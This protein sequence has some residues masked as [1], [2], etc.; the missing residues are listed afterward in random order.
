MRPLT[1][2]A[3][4]L[5]PT[6]LAQPA[7]KPAA[8]APRP[9]APK[10]LDPN[11]PIPPVGKPL[12]PA[13]RA[14]LENAVANLATRIAV[15]KKDLAA[16]PELLA[17]VPDIQIYHNAVRYPLQY[18]EPIDVKQAHQ[19][20][21]DAG[22]RIDQLTAGDVK[23]IHTT[24][25][26]GY[27]SAIDGS[28]QPYNLS[29]PADYK[30][31]DPKK[32]RVD[33]WAHGRNENLTELAFL[34]SKTKE[35]QPA[36]HFVVYLYGRYCNAN[37]FAGEVDCFE[38]LADLKR[39]V[40]VD[41]NRL[42]TIGFSMGGAAV[43]QFATHYTD[44][45]AAASP[46][47]GFSESR[48]F[49]KIKPDEIAAMQPWE[50][51]LWHWYDCTDWVENL[52]MLPTVAYAGELD[53]QKQASDVMLREAAKEQVKI[54]R[55]IGP[56]TAHK[57]EP[58]TK[59]KI[60]A[61]L[62]EI[63]AKGRDRLPSKIRFTTYT[64]RYPNMYWVRLTGL[65]RHWERA[66]VEASID[67]PDAITVKT[68]NVTAMTLDV[69]GGSRLNPGAPAKVHIDEQSIATSTNKDGSLT[70]PLIKSDGRWS[71]G[72]YALVGRHSGPGTSWTGILRKTPGLQGPIDDAF[73]TP[74]LFVEPTGKTNV[75][76]VDKWVAAEFK[77]AVDH[78]RKQFRGEPRVKRDTDVTPD[79]IANYNLVCFG[80]PASN[81]VLAKVA[82]KLPAKW[83]A[84][85]LTLAGDSVDPK[86]HIPALI[87]PN[88]LNPNRYIVLN[89]GFT[90]REFDYYNNARQTPKLPDYAL[91]DVTAPI[92]PKV[93]S[94]I[95]HA[96][97]FDEQWRAPAAN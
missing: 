83:S 93:P 11:R 38:A 15:L 74:F 62:D 69:P 53:G 3:L 88:P 97:F 19:A 78:W 66:R 16:K 18:D 17:L 23:W 14:A 67:G 65:E 49:L 8:P 2:L 61:R 54:E 52:A 59:K 79:D 44:V 30:P 32:Y 56:Q 26:R 72:F 36:T 50:R 70:L 25:P 55:L 77:H 92:T 48:E 47:A 73:M 94:K 89:S 57:Y 40:P 35:H 75:D 58:E 29:V 12:A 10:P 24:G 6:L 41:E 43:W 80:T 84:D 60:D 45:W 96:G 81:T 7:P 27:V 22:M 82:D 13:D 85:S 33:F 71:A 34:N 21:V 76:A 91:I 86:T 42:V 51:S 68:Q 20:I 46:G 9:P 1:L 37:K 64:L 95:T 39:R 90:F 28:V 87:Y 5:S 4:L 31:G 63:V